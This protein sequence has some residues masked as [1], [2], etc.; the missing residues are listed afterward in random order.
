MIVDNNGDIEGTVELPDGFHPREIGEDY[1]LALLLDEQGVER[2]V[3]HALHEHP[4]R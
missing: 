2:I 3:L 4:A 1:I